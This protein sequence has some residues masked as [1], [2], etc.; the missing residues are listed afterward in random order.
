MRGGGV[1][2]GLT[3]RR[4]SPH[5]EG[6]HS[7]GISTSGRQSEVEALRARVQELETVLALEQAE[8]AG[9]QEDALS[10]V[11][12]AMT[13]CRQR[14]EEEIAR[15]RRVAQRAQERLCVLREAVF[16]EGIDLHGLYEDASFASTDAVEHRQQLLDALGEEVLRELVAQEQKRAAEGAPSDP[17][18]VGENVRRAVARCFQLVVRHY[19]E[20]L[21]GVAQG[22]EREVNALSAARS[23]EGQ[24]GAGARWE[25]LEANLDYERQRNALLCVRMKGSLR[26]RNEEFERRVMDKAEELVA[27]YKQR[28]D[29]ASVR[30]SEFESR[31]SH[32]RAEPLLSP[33]SHHDTSCQRFVREVTRQVRDATTEDTADGRLH[34]ERDV[35][36]KAQQLL[37]KYRPVV[38]KDR[39]KAKREESP[40]DRVYDGVTRTAGHIRPCPV[41][42]P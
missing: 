23:V 5:S 36:N 2:P 22:F 35:L 8:K 28:A 12:A 31:F 3:S 27:D 33:P 14:A 7:N 40:E 11:D 10:K 9:F 26:K 19:E 38:Q 21:E 39:S 16:A 4:S 13:T 6:H 1:M 24:D 41:P 29:A 34:F 37:E 42:Y 20:I 32:L 30:V 17:D 15:H 18:S 25:A